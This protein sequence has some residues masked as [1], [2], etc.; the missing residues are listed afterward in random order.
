MIF[1]F[2]KIAAQRLWRCYNYYIGKRGV[3]SKEEVDKYIDQL[4]PGQANILKTLRSEVISEFPQLNEKFKWSMP[5]YTLNDQD[6][7]YFQATKQGVNFGFN[8]G[9]RLDDPQDL[10]EGTGKN[11]RHIK[12]HDTD[13]LD[14]EYLKELLSQAIEL[15]SQ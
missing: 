10:L 8:Q 13:S 15:A 5:V 12:V 2:K 9:S 14:L 3:I 6:V 4:D 7:T 1:R 11:M